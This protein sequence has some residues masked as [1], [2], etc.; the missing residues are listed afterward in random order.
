[1]STVESR[2]YDRGLWAL[3]RLSLTRLRRALLK[4][5]RGNVLEV[6]IGTGAN[7]PYYRDG[8][9][10][11]GLDA[12]LAMLAGARSRSVGQRSVL[13][14]A[15]AHELP[16]RANQFDTIVST[17]V[18]CCIADPAM[19]LA[20]IKRVLKP[21]GTFLLLEHVRGQGPI[22]RRITDWLHPVWFALQGE[23]HLN[24]ETAASVQSAGFEITRS[25]RHGWGL[26]QLIQAIPNS[27]S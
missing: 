8:S 6:G 26:L 19:A 13:T 18:F 16:F 2:R 22:S 25:E 4:I 21:D 11:A 3:E 27:A 17:L 12:N 5:V 10:V 9:L 23:C 7:L 24:R 14:C 20:E 1:M 15:D